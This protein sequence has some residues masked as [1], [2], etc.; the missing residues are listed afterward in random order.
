MSW[1]SRRELLAGAG[2]AL[3]AGSA[4][5]LGFEVGGNSELE[6]PS[7]DDTE[8]GEPEPAWE[9][10]AELPDGLAKALTFVF[11]SELEADSVS[12]ELQSSFDDEP[13]AEEPEDRI[14]FHLF[15]R[16]TGAP[17]TELGILR[18]EFIDED[19]RVHNETDIAWELQLSS[20][21][22]SQ[23][24]TGVST[25]WVGDIVMD[26][27]TATAEY[28]GFRLYPEQDRQFA[29]DGEVALLGDEKWV[30]ETIAAVKAGEKPYA[31]SYPRV[32]ETLLELPDGV[33]ATL[34]DNSEHIAGNFGWTDEIV[35]VPETM[36]ISI[37][38]VQ[39]T[40]IVN[41]RTY[42][43]I[44]W[45]SEP[46]D[47]PT[48]EW[49]V[50]W[51]GEL[52]YEEPG[53]V[54]P[55]VAEPILQVTASYPFIPEENRPEIPNP[56]VLVGYDEQQEEVLFGFTEGDTVETRQLS[57]AIEDEPY[58]GDW[59]RGQETIAAGDVIAVDADAIEPG[60]SLALR[61]QIPEFEIEEE[62]SYRVLDELP[63]E[64]FYDP[65]T[66][67][68]TIIYGN[69]PPLPGD[70][71]SGGEF[72]NIEDDLA[73]GIDGALTEGDSVTLTE[74]PF[75]ATAE[76]RYERS[77]EQ[78]RS[79][80]YFPADPPGAFT[81]DREDERLTI[82]YSTDERIHG[83]PVV[84]DFEPVEEIGTGATESTVGVYHA[85]VALDADRYE[86]RVDGEPAP[87]QWTDHTETIEEGE[88]LVLEGVAFGEEVSIVWLDAADEPH[89]VDDHT[90]LPHVEFEAEYHEESEAMTIRHA[91]G[92]TVAG[93]LAI[94]V[95][96][97]QERDRT[98]DWPGLVVEPGDSI[99]ITDVPMGSTVEVSLLGHTLAYIRTRQYGEDHVIVEPRGGMNQDGFV[100]T[101]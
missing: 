19:E 13:D 85:P 77:D 2:S 98:T 44:C 37:G 41:R 4:G 100:V 83:S 86:I 32:A 17:N 43:V 65:D 95:D 25:V 94:L 5:C 49:F 91:E 29:T 54:E 30:L 7:D 57:V 75:G 64:Y 81:F 23:G 88:S 99:L 71:L 101:D 11:P 73:D 59:A 9:L 45:Y 66:E 24:A 34:F 48:V 76:L 1:P 42:D 10:P 93:E 51:A 96:A 31:A 27:E 61:Y 16:R 20:G 55:T 80:G 26:A 68:I 70:R 18:D 67:E 46:P 21:L 87:R 36:V 28:A 40:D 58:D 89:E 15:D 47:E 82:T 63:F 97:E 22:F 52:G 92:E 72:M 53:T 50:D 38:D 35:A 60:D 79:L 62:S 78:T 74:I 84:F 3:L 14:Q 6:R 8:H 33:D 56:P 90:V 39:E 12:D 69:G